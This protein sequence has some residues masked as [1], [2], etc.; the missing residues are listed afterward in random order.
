MIDSK[1]PSFRIIAPTE[2]TATMTLQN[3]FGRMYTEA[4]CEPRRFIINITDDV[5]NIVYPTKTTTDN[6]YLTSF[7]VFTYDGFYDN[8]LEAFRVSF[9]SYLFND[10][11]HL[12][13]TVPFK[14]YTID[15]IVNQMLGLILDMKIENKIDLPERHFSKR[16]PEDFLSY[17]RSELKVNVD[18]FHTKHEINNLSL[19]DKDILKLDQKLDRLAFDEDFELFCQICYDSVRP[20][21]TDSVTFTSLLKCGH[22][23]CDDC[24]RGHSLS[25]ISNGCL[26]ISCP[27]YAC[28]VIVDPI[29][30]LSL[31]NVKDVGLLLQRQQEDKLETSEDAQ[32]CPNPSCG[33]VI[34]MKVNRKSAG[35]CYDVTCACGTSCCF[36][37][38]GDPHW[39][40]RCDQAG[41]YAN[42]VD[43]I[44]L[45]VEVEEEHTKNPPATQAPK[46]KKKPKE[47]V[48]M[49]EGRLCPRCKRFINKN[50]GCP[51]MF[52]KCR[53][54]FCWTCMLPYGHPAPCNPASKLVDE[55]TRTIAVRHIDPKDVAPQPL[56]PKQKEP[57]A[58]KEKSRQRTSMY[59]KAKQQRLES[60]ESH[61]SNKALGSLA[62]K[63]AKAASKDG[64][65]MKQI[66]QLCTDNG[67]SPSE[68]HESHD[69]LVPI[70][71]KAITKFL[72]SCD[73]Q[74]KALHHVVEFTFVLLH[75]LPASEDKRRALALAND[76]SGFTSFFRYVKHV[77]VL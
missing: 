46:S 68:V 14:T 55:L 72:Q 54:E 35:L 74:R 5:R 62:L 33:R 1:L 19:E 13:N 42:K 64:E 38:L 39:P 71:R 51:Y 70:T 18:S 29:T 77:L 15:E 56:E 34:K 58:V 50:G 2:E 48:M 76:L 37:C 60:S 3:K 24:W 26:G 53:Y 32:W 9:N 16:K 47:T 11:Q 43:D 22:I 28:D 67:D 12:D 63:I 61:P 40:A 59:Q 45:P 69:Q 49:V 6:S 27:G 25:K 20:N 75:D 31:V 10:S 8:G 52:C 57:V 41:S 73:L 44:E 4:N 21:Q 66:S 65:F 17:I 30:L 7:L 36:S 23:F